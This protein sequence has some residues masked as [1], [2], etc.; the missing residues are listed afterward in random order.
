MDALPHRPARRTGRRLHW[1]IRGLHGMWIVPR[2]T[3]LRARRTA[4]G[5]QRHPFEAGVL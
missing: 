3:S 1:P 5:R 4:S 2:W